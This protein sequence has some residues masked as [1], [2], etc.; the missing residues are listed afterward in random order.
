[1][2]KGGALHIHDFSIASNDWIVSDVTYREGLY[3]C[4][5]DDPDGYP[6]FTWL[7][8]PDE[9]SQVPVTCEGSS[10]SDWMSMSDLRLESG[11]DA[12]DKYIKSKLVLTVDDPADAYP[13]VNTVWAAFENRLLVLNSIIYY[14]PVVRDF[15][16]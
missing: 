15:V 6:R 3:M 12:V 13:D 16:Q 5:P 10:S 8:S 14:E 11:A 7:N 4:Q 9:T 1:M 2:P